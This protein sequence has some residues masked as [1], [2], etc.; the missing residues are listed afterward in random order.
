MP[1]N[2]IEF[3]TDDPQRFPAPF[4]ANR[5][6]PQWLKDMPIDRPLEAQ[7]PTG[8]ETIPV[9]T[10]KQC[11]PFIEAMTCGYM[12]PLAGDVTFRMD[13]TGGLTFTAAGK[14]IGT[15]HPL[16]TQGSPFQGKQIVKFMNPWVVKTPPGYSALFLQPPNQFELPF[17]VLAGLVETDT[18][19]RPVHFP[20]VCLMRP[21]TTVSLKRGTP[22]AQVIPVKREDWQSQAVPWDRDARVRIEQEM[23][24]DRHTF[25]KDRFWVKKSY[26]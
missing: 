12:I 9:P 2:L 26:G 15:Q 13:A 4:P 22:I 5:A 16:Q 10:V 3:H 7:R 17:Q 20:S 11:P 1:R 18:Y 14:I 25:Y 21:G 6:V 24:A 23:A 19:Y 8:P